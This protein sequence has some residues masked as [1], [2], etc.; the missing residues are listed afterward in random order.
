M[1]YEYQV[2]GLM[3]QT[4]DLICTTDGGG[5]DI[6]G[7]FWRLVGKLIPGDVD[8]IVIYTGPGGHCIEAGARG[9]VTAFDMAGSIWDSEK[10]AG[11]RGML[12]DEIY[13]VAY[14]LEGKA[15]DEAQSARIRENI[16]NYCV[17]QIG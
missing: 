15:L 16:A 11:Q 3:V 9:M 5:A 13:G 7:Q 17:Q 4:G 12:I 2:N 6:K 8:H 1:T 14:P 10:M